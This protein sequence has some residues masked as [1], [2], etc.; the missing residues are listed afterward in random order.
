M[1]RAIDESD[2]DWRF[3]RNAR[4]PGEYEY[5][6][7]MARNARERRAQREAYDGWVA[8]L[9]GTMLSPEMLASAVFIPGAIGRGALYSGTRVGGLVGGVELANEAL[10]HQ[11]DPTMTVAE[12][13]FAVGVST[14]FAGAIGG[15]LGALGQREATRLAA[16]MGEEIA[17]MGGVSKFTERLMYGEDVATVVRLADGTRMPE[18]RGESGVHFDPVNRTVTMSAADVQRGW[19]NKDWRRLGLDDELFP[20]A[21]SWGEFLIRYEVEKAPKVVDPN[22]TFAPMVADAEGA[23]DRALKSFQTWRIDNRRGLQNMAARMVHRLADTP[24]KRVHRSAL[25]AEARDLVDAIGA[26]AAF[27][28][29]AERGGRTIGASVAMMTPELVQGRGTMLKLAEDMAYEKYLAQGVERSNPRIGDV[30]IRK[31]FM[32]GR[33]SDGSRGMDVPTFRREATLAYITGERSGIEAVDEYADALAKFYEAFQRD[34]TEINLTNRPTIVARMETLRARVAKIEAKIASIEANPRGMTDKAGKARQSMLQEKAEIEVELDMLADKPVTPVRAHNYFTRIWSRQAMRQYPVT[35]KKLIAREFRK[36]PEGWIWK[37]QEGGAAVLTRHKFDM[38]EESLQRRVDEFF[39]DTLNGRVMSG[40]EHTPGTAASFARMRLLEFENKDLVD[41]PLDP[42]EGMGRADFIETDAQLVA[43]TYAQRMGPSIAD[44]RRFDFGSGADRG[45]E[46]ALQDVLDREAAAF[47]GSAKARDK[48]LLAID[49]DIRT[50]RDRVLR[51]LVDEPD[52]FDNRSVAVLKNMS[53]LAYM[54]LSGIATIPDAGKLVMAHGVSEVASGAMRVLDDSVGSTK[55]AK[56]EMRQAGGM[57]D[58]ALNIAVS[59]MAEVGTDPIYQNMFERALRG[60]VNK[61]FIAN[62][63][64]PLTVSM[65]AFDGVIR[66]HRLVTDAV[67]LAGGKAS[68]EQTEF[69]AQYG[70]GE[71]MAKR[72]ASQPWEKHT[73]DGYLLANTE[74]WGDAGAVRAFRAALVQGGEN[75]ILLA[76]AADKPTL[77]DGVVHFRAGRPV[78]DRLAEAM[79][80]RKVTVKAGSNE[81]G[82]KRIAGAYWRAQSGIYGMPFTYW[83]YGLAATNKVLATSLENPSSAALSGIAAMLGLGYISSELRF[84]VSGHHFTWDAMTLP[85]KMVHI[86][87]KSGTAG[88]LPDVMF[89]AQGAVMATTGFNPLPFDKRGGRESTPAD[90]AFDI[91]GAPSSIARSLVQGGFEAA[92]GQGT[93]RLSWAGPGRNYPATRWI[94]EA[95]NDASEPSAGPHVSGRF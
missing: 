87:D 77:V 42:S 36:H 71:A 66:Q 55:L 39:E 46:E 30:P 48:H 59:R 44:A 20:N 6:Q 26:D 57:A 3:L 51:R 63:L 90:I 43:N 1:Q 24:Y 47:K 81:D 28:S 74:A 8:P 15:G 25:T 76:S 14:L 21:S 29:V 11:N 9:L 49:R 75:T 73:E 58:V 79:G 27:A 17:A 69:L 4:S 7:G 80:L 45:F 41:V 18:G 86:V 31:S 35:F 52:R 23:L 84:A 94:Y 37:K 93:D 72:I 85:E 33:L 5:M 88:I 19:Q 40:K 89:K 22:A 60:G 82:S 32:E 10:R 83:N 53:H 70:I 92:S 95:I 12:S 64:A 2:P 68:A 34:L 67:A 13:A 54:G 50:M 62:G 65:R 38:D 91:M 61:F 16:Q 56:N 78:V